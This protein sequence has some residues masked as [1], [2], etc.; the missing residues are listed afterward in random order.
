MKVSRERINTVAA[1]THRQ[2][3]TALEK[4][5]DSATCS[6][7]CCR[8]ADSIDAEL[9]AVKAAGAPVA[10]ATG[11]TFCCHLRVGVFPH[12]AIAL[13]HYLR[14]SL[15]PLDAAVIEQRI[16]DNAQ[17]ID[18]MTVQEHYAARLPCAFLV[19]GRCSVHEI[20]PSS[21]ASYHS[22]SRDRC[23]HGFDHPEG[24]GTPA[25]SRPASLQLTAFCDAVTEA[26]QAGLEDAGLA[27]RKSELHQ[28]V[29]ALIQSSGVIER[30]D[31]GG[32]VVGGSESADH[33]G[34]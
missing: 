19:E 3:T 17:A 31:R 21:C 12:E 27:A 2:T 5:R 26:T 4:A 23:K 10:C 13:F 15:P 7:L 6:A 20:R 32:A 25:N 14:T 16:I 18:G 33:D 34:Y 22:L 11:C 30:W 24:M 28:L 8:L 1:T 29:R 9:E